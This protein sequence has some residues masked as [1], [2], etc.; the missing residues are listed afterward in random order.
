MIF[1]GPPDPAHG[2]P[3]R[4][5]PLPAAA[6]AGAALAQVA[7]ELGRVARLVDELETCLI[8]TDDDTPAA[9]RR[10]VQSLDLL[11]QSVSALQ[12]YLATLSE[13]CGPWTLPMAPALAQV[14]LGDMRDRL[15][16]AGRPAP[17][18]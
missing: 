2:E 6:P 18:E 3:V 12:R 13:G 11:A 8:A 4:P 14:P 10:T 1:D 7:D 9:R 17:P 5:A 16:G 15:A